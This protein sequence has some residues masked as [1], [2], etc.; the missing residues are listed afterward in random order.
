[1]YFLQLRVNTYGNRAKKDYHVF[2]G[3][4]NLVHKME[5]Q[6]LRICPFGYP[7][8]HYF[9]YSDYTGEQWFSGT[10]DECVA[11]IGELKG[12]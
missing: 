5:Y 8:T 7:A 9:V 2:I 11:F 10:Y 12:F 1:M 4:I 3:S 6:Y